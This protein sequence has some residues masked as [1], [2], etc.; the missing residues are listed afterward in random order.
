MYKENIGGPESQFA[1]A[2]FR[3]IGAIIEPKADGSIHRF[4][5]PEARRGNAACWYF[6]HMDGLPAGAYGNW[7]NAFTKTWRGQPER[8]ITSA[9]RERQKL[10]VKYAKA[11]REAERSDAREQARRRAARMWDK[12]EPADSRHPYLISKHLEGAGLRQLARKSHR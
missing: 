3:D 6:L 11:R 10:L 12:A 7:R 8:H 5:D 1:D 4:D 2:I 9:E